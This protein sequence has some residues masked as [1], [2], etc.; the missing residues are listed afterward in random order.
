MWSTTACGAYLHPLSLSL[1]ISA[2]D[3][4]HL[5]LSASV[6]AQP[7]YLPS[8]HLTAGGQ[9]ER[10][11]HLSLGLQLLP[12]RKSSKTECDW[13]KACSQ[14]CSLFFL[15]CCMCGTDQIYKKHHLLITSFVLTPNT[16]FSHYSNWLW[17]CREE[18]HEILMTKKRQRDVKNEHTGEAKLLN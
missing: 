16:E 5:P 2:S 14:I 11:R 12:V 18:V 6:S 17:T 7:L 8:F 15:L 1:A 9:G 4:F 13:G 3:S 10:F